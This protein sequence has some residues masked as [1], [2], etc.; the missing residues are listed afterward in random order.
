MESTS[1]EYAI[2]IVEMTTKFLEQ[3]INLVDNAWSVL[4]RIDAN[5]ERTSTVGN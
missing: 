2:E 5:F 4:K 3:C 1:G